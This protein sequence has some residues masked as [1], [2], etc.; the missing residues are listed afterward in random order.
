MSIKPARH[1][2]DLASNRDRAEN[3]QSIKERRNE[4]IKRAPYYPVVSSLRLLVCIVYIYGMHM[5]STRSAGGDNETER[6]YSY[7][8][9]WHKYR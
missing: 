3:I 4:I 5:W 1:V 8:C 6:F 7:N 9:I 2:S